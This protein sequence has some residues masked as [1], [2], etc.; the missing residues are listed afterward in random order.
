MHERTVVIPEGVGL[1]ARPASRFVEAAAA[2]GAEVTISKDGGEAVDA[3]SILS[4]L[5]LD[6]RGGDRVTLR[7][8]GA[9]GERVAAELA[10][11][12]EAGDGDA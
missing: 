6:V 9:D 2:A 3:R 11:V 7:V 12:L 8:D 1:H 10:A 5:G 4:V